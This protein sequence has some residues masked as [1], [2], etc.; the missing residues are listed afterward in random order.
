MQAPAGITV[1]QIQSVLDNF[2]Y[3]AANGG[4]APPDRPRRRTYDTNKLSD[5][6]Q[7]GSKVWDALH[8]SAR[9]HFARFFYI[10]DEDVVRLI[11]EAACYPGGVDRNSDGF[12]S[13]YDRV[14]EWRKNWGSRFGEAVDK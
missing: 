7:N 2:F 4:A 12:R 9:K 13:A 6:F 3:P 11:D 14:L 1:D 5:V 10:F 8:R